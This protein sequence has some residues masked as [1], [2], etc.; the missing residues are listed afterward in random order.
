MSALNGNGNGHGHGHGSVD[1]AAIAQAA[2]AERMAAAVV[3]AF[4]AC[5]D[6][7]IGLSEVQKIALIEALLLQFDGFTSRMRSLDGVGQLLGHLGHLGQL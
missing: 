4:G 1:T 3:F 7:G 2:A 5:E 6:A